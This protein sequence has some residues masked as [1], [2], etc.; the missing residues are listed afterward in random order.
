MNEPREAQVVLAAIRERR[1]VK[2]VQPD[3]VPRELIEQLLEA[4]VWAPN[5]HLTQPWRFFVLTGEARVALGEVLARD[6]ALAPDK[7][8]VIRQ[9]PL[10]APVLIAVAVEPDPKRPLLD[11]IA[12][13]AAAVQNLLLAAHALGLGAIWRTGRAIED[14]AVKAFLGL[15]D[16]AVLLGFVYLGFPAVVPEPPA[17][18]PAQ[19]VTV[20]FDAETTRSALARA[21]APGEVAPSPSDGPST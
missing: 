6:P 14:P 17:R 3:P 4:A 9:K 1:S 12:A 19:E 21:L 11:E 2:Q 13:G 5:H 16:R 8:A 7:R 15:P 20:W 10:R 18:R